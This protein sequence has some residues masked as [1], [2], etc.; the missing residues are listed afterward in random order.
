MGREN[1]RSRVVVIGLLVVAFI[2]ITVDYR[3]S[4]SSSGLRGVLRGGFATVEGA[5][6]AVT[7]PIGRTVS[8]LAH[9]NRYQRRADALAAENAD[10]KRQLADDAEVRRQAAGLANLRLLADR[11]QY[12]IIAARVIAIGDITGTEWSVTVNAGSADGVIPDRLV[13]DSDGLVG[14]VLSSTAHTAVIR[15]ACDPA[16]HIGARLEGA[17]LL[18]AVAGTGS[19]DALAFT[20]YDATRQVKVGDRVVSF[21]SADYV[22]GVP[23]GVVTKV[24]DMSE[25]LSRSAEVT[26]FAAIGSLDLVG[27]VVGKLPADAGDRVLPPRPVPTPASPASP[28]A[29]TAPTAPPAPPAK[30]PVTPA[31]APAATAAVG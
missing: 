17:R 21:G 1:R 11:G 31:L 25:G 20:L 23:I 29:P 22:G 10:L 13:L 19:P 5:L 3:S 16:S 12:S 28:A 26:P 18:G 15:L 14:A 9:P 2:L 7:R 8:S 24:L 30:V 4:D 6:T 27:I